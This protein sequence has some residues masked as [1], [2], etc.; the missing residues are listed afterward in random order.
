[1]VLLLVLA[2]AVLCEGRRFRRHH[3]ARPRRH[4]YARPVAVA[5]APLFWLS[6]IQKT[7]RHL[8]LQASRKREEERRRKEQK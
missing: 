6:G 3:Y 2:L 4:H 8:Q 7:I 1:M 5:S